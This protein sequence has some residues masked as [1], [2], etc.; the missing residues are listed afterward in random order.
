VCFINETFGSRFDGSMQSSLVAPILYLHN[1]VNYNKQNMR[2]KTLPKVPDTD[3]DLAPETKSE[4]D[5][6]LEAIQEKPRK[7]VVKS[8]LEYLQELGKLGFHNKSLWYRGIGNTNHKL[9]P[10]LFRHRTAKTKTE[11]R[12]VE[13]N[14]N[15]TFRMRS[16][17]YADSS[18]WGN[19]GDWDQLFF[20]QHYRVPTRLLDW[21]GSP[22]VSLHFALTS[23]HSNPSGAPSTDAAVWVLDPIAWNSAVYAGT[24]FTGEVLSPKDSRL[25]RYAP[26]EVYDSSTN[27]P[28]VA[29]RGTN[30]SARIVAQQGFFTIFGPEKKSMEQI[31][32]EQKLESGE[33]MFPDDCLI[34]FIFPKENVASMKEEMFALGVSE[35]TIYPDL[36]GLALEL[37]RICGF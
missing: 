10:S 1:R 36:E 37:K 2:R 15:E 6:P 35:A 9:I 31:F 21:S 19:E 17:P 8:A 18:R 5:A 3:S 26:G 25:H 27:I 7:I 33:R 13:E 24:R 16:F 34:R 22:L 30:N 28:P 23:V 11:F 29:M 4:A 20:M 14:L 12:G 32:L